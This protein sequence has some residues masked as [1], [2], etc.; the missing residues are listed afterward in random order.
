VPL[1]IVV[2]VA[3]AWAVTSPEPAIDTWTS[4]AAGRH[5]AAHGVSDED[6]FSFASRPPA[7]AA[8]PAG[9]TVWQRLRAWALPSGWINQAWAGHLVLYGAYEAGGLGGLLVLK[10]LAYIAVGILLVSHARLRGARPELATATAAL[11][12][13]AYRPFAQVRPQLFTDL[14]AAAFLLA[15]TL[16]QRRDRRFLWAV[17]P[18]V[19]VW[20]NLHGGFVFALVLLAVAAA[21]PAAATH[22]QSARRAAWRESAVLLMV[23]AGALVGAVVASPFRLANLLHLVEITVG[24]D[25]AEWRMVDE[26]RPLTTAS[27]LDQ[28]TWAATALLAAGTAIAAWCGTRWARRGNGAAT[29]FDLQ[30]A[31]MLAVALALAF[32]SLRFVPLACLVA[33][34]LIAAW[35]EQTLAARG[36][37]RDPG[38]PRRAVLA[39]APWTAAG[40][41]L[42]TFTA[43]LSAWALQ[44]WPLD[45]R[46][47]SVA[48]RLLQTYDR[49]WDACAFL[50]A[51]GWRGNLWNFW[52]EGGF[53]SWCQDPDPATGR[54]PLQ[55]WIDPRAQVAFP[56][57][58]SREYGLFMSGGPSGA[59]ALAAGGSLT[60]RAGQQGM[61]WLERRLRELG[62][63][64]AHVPEQWSQTFPGLAL[65]TLPAWRAVY[66]DER[67][68]IIVDTRTADGR[69]WAAA[70]DGGALTYPDPAAAL[71]AQ[72]L[73]AA[74]GRGSD[75]GR[76]AVELA[77]QAYAERP[78]ARA[79]AVAVAAARSP[80]VAAAAEAFCDEVAAELLA[81]RARWSAAD[82][83]SLQLAAARTALEFL[84]QRA[85]LRG[86]AAAARRAGEGLAVVAADEARA[87]AARAW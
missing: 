85:E 3:A 21:T 49:P 82:G 71:L 31:A 5:I 65:A 28:A 18:L 27:P 7:R 62:T 67:H 39:A 51:N 75:G 4:L 70:A 61:V 13:A 79:V 24:P 87:A 81:A 60:P 86:D 42:L 59:A 83:Y 32:K 43:W 64:V 35:S 10:W 8:L 40:L 30:A 11:A 58:V 80:A 57:A 25:A 14:L 74:R 38:A 1:A 63:A 68:T 55:V 50:R 41:A 20:S 84:A 9:A 22:R 78:S 66:A 44:P 19:A 69:A 76:R 17:P 6:P 45:D 47:T 36:R 23:L 37:G 46:R 15:L 2:L 53:L 72:A 34:P 29:P 52:E 48:D 26:W 77:R 56:A 12:L 54:T 16:A 33:A 73:N